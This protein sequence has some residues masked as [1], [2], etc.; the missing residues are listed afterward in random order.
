MQNIVGTFDDESSARLAMNRLLE[1][2]IARERLYFQPSVD[3]EFLAHA[4]NVRNRPGKP[5]Y[6]PKGVLESFGGF[7]AHL[8]ESHT[9]ESGI[10]SEAMRRGTCL[11]LA[12][13]EDQD[14]AKRI[15]EVLEDSGAVG[16]EDR[17]GQWRAEG[18]VP[19]TQEGASHAEAPAAAGPTGAPVGTH[20]FT[21]GGATVGMP[22]PSGGAM[23]EDL[24]DTGRD[25]GLA[26]PAAPTRGSQTADERERAVA[27]AERGG[28]SAPDTVNR[29][30]ERR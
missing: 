7:F 18:W 17:V 2:G 13:A 30:R 4:G 14:E 6:K 28:A 15:I 9:D 5:G 21:G 3:A 24:G 22:T 20:S 12:R 25:P 19:P 29:E 11:L 23:G 16:L 1:M 8:F 10:Y 27:A 26:N